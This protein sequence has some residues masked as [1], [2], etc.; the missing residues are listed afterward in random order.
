MIRLLILTIALASSISFAESDDFTTNFVIG[1]YL[2]IGKAVDSDTTYTGKVEIYSQDGGLKANRIINGKTVLAT[3]AIESALKGD[4]KVL[5]I[6]F[7]ENGTK[8]AET[9]LW[10]SDLDNYARISCYLY[11]PG[12]KTM[13]PGLESLFNDHTAK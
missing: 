7:T 10:Q 3:A 1:K 13:N 9:C 6:R 2:L 11:Q 8:Y 5:R 12:V 4:A